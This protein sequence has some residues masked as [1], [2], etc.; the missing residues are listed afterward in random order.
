MR[1]RLDLDLEFKRARRYALKS[2]EPMPR[3]QDRC[4]YSLNELLDPEYD[5]E[6][7]LAKLG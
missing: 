7:L 5:L 6:T 1:N 2:I 4:P 3:V